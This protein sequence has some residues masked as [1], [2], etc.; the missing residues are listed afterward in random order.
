[1]ISVVSKKVITSCSSVLTRAPE[2]KV[3]RILINF[4]DKI[5]DKMLIWFTTLP[6]QASLVPPAQ[7]CWYN[8]FPKQYAPMMWPSHICLVRVIY[9]FFELSQSQDMTWSSRVTSS[10]WFASTCQ[11]QV[12]WKLTL[13][14]V[15]FC[16]NMA[17]NKLQNCAQRAKQWC[18]MLF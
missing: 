8:V 11:C 5:D 14:H 1:M 9:K 13:F 6:K 3:R 18:S 17:L 15:F 2:T 16:Y 12:K 4:N 10:L 7:E